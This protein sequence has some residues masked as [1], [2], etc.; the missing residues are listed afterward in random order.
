MDD[1]YDVI[2]CGT[3]LKECILS[4]LL[5][6]YGKKVLHVDRNPYY[7]GESASLNL[8]NLFQH[9]RPGEKPPESY[10]A[11][12]DW[13]VDRIPKFVMAGGILVQMLLKTRVSDYLEWQVIEGTY[14]YQY[15][16]GGFFSSAKSI[17][18]VPSN[19]MEALKSPL[20]GLTEKMACR[21]FFQFCQAWDMEKKDTWKGFD[22]KETPMR[23][24]YEHFGL[25]ANTIDFVGHAVALHVNDDY[26]EMPMGPT[27]EKIKLYMTSISRYGTSPFIY[28]VYGLGGLPEGFSRKAAV[29]GAAFML[30]QQVEKF[31][32][33]DQGKVC[34]V[35]N[36]AGE[37]AKCK[38]VVCD[39]TY[40][41]DLPGKVK[42]TGRVIR[43]ICILT[44]PIPETGDKSSCQI[45]IPQKQLKRHNDIY[46]TM[47]SSKHG[48]IKDGKYVALVSTQVET[49]DPEKEV[50]VAVNL[51]GEVD[52][53]FT[54]IFDTYETC[55]DGT[56]DN[57]FVST[58]YDA[59][60][61]FES[62]SHN[63]MTMWKCITGE[64]LDL[65]VKP[66]E[67]R[68]PDE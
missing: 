12:R 9:F 17:H 52:N 30:N 18:K 13:N 34:G 50:E 35:Q 32:F 15:Q 61:H 28:P 59:T 36:T 45:I 25:G 40:V 4:G 53:K 3:G 43:V 46:I 49:D 60:S 54:E 29:A 56:K 24:V 55:D 48:V 5:S 38:T 42:K 11:D 39:P 44:A 14:V 21:S 27:M 1:E 67:M 63:V 47:L 31:V 23:K 51:L 68:N 7:G 6:C 62:A 58:S 20:M 37:V 26:I 64:D 8:K 41:K 57:V 66:D 22:P 65:T 10:G 19:D 33:D 2:V 16:K